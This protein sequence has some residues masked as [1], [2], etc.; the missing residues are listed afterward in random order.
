[1]KNFRLQP[2]TLKNRLRHFIFINF[3]VKCQG[4]FVPT[5]NAETDKMQENQENTVFEDSQHLF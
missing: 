5:E 3:I 1:L 4:S 2:A